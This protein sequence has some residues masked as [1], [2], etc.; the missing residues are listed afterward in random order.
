MNNENT[1]CSASAHGLIC[2]ENIGTKPGSEIAAGL[3]WMKFK[4]SIAF[5]IF[6][7]ISAPSSIFQHFKPPS[8]VELIEMLCNLHNA[9]STT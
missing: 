4:L 5:C 6:F 2:V 9:D 8:E 7:L 1:K 3:A